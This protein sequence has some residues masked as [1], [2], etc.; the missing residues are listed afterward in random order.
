MNYNYEMKAL[1]M[2]TLLDNRSKS[3][4]SD[5]VFNAIDMM[6]LFIKRY[7]GYEN[8]LNNIMDFIEKDDRIEKIDFYYRTKYLGGTVFEVVFKVDEEEYANFFK[9]FYKAL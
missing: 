5:K 8:R 7:E 4:D 1:I 2:D 3:V 9:V 6:N